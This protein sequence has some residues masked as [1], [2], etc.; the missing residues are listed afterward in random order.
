VTP[1]IS[2]SSRLS[3]S[4]RVRASPSSSPRC[5]VRSRRA[6]S[7]LSPMILS[8]SESTMRAVP[9]RPKSV[10]LDADGPPEERRRLIA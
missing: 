7:W 3:R 1:R 4:N 10:W 8:T 2:S 6:S 9:S 5:S